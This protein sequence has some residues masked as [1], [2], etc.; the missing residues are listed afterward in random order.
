MLNYDEE[1]N[2]N[3]KIHVI[4]LKRTKSSDDDALCALIHIPPH[5]NIIMQKRMK[6]KKRKMKQTRIGKLK[7]DLKS[8]KES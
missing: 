7:N 4:H 5:I 6:K 8:T 1:K 3:E 2:E